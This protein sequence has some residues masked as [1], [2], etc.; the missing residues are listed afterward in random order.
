MD[1]ETAVDIAR[2]PL[3]WDSVPEAVMPSLA[4]TVTR[5]FLSGEMLTV[6][7]VA[8]AADSEMEVHS[9]P[10]EQFT[11]VL[12]GTMEFLVGGK[13]VTVQEGEILHLPAHVPHGARSIGEAVV[14]DMF[15]PPRADWQQ[16]T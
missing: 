13:P 8:F 6:A 1:P 11:L 15:A 5:R 3:D 2:V 10:N 7:R 9:H 12:S 4:G 16:P 14:L